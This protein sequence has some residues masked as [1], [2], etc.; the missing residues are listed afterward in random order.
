MDRDLELLHA[1]REGDGNA[2]DELLLR[3]HK[4]IWRTVATKIPEP[5][6]EDLVH[7]VIET[8]IKRRDQLHSDVKFR[9]YAMAVTRRMIQGFIRERYRKPVDLAGLMGNSVQEL[10]VGPSSIVLAKQQDRL[11]L[12]ALRSLPLDDQFVLELYYWEGMT[13]PELAAVF[14]LLEPTVRG[15]LRRAKERLGKKMVELAR[16]HHELAETMTNFDRWA[17]GVREAIDHQG[18]D[19]SA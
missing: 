18:S 10:G 14:D 9:S 2:G 19:P 12:E 13:G 17:A 5:A 15:R 6:V 4:L 8:L 11:L 1:W 3:Y 7:E 16:H